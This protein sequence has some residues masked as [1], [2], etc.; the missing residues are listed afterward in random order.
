MPTLTGAPQVCR[1]NLLHGVQG[2]QRPGGLQP[3]SFMGWAGLVGSSMADTEHQRGAFSPHS[4]AWQ[5]HQPLPA[6]SIPFPLSPREPSHSSPTR[7]A[8]G[9]SP[10]PSLPPPFSAWHHLPSWLHQPAEA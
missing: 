1:A 4:H 6:P 3:V 7:R 5:T 10:K 9:P 2:P 8:K